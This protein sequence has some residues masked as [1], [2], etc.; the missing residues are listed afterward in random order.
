MVGGYLTFSGVDVKGRWGRTPVQEVL[1]VK[2]SDVDDRC[3]HCEGVMPAAVHP[4]KALEKVRGPWPAFLGYNKTELA[5]GADLVMTIDGDPLYRLFFPRQGK[6]RRFYL[7]LLTP[8]GPPGLCQLGVLQ[9]TLAGHGRL[10]DWVIL[11][12]GFHQLY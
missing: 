5:P 11:P 7:G 1:P 10:S 3:E 8:L 4:H 2:V 12:G 9:Q 6:K